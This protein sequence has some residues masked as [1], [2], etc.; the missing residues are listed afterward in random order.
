LRARG[1]SRVR[2]RR[3]HEPPAER[4]RGGRRDDLVDVERYEPFRARHRRRVIGIPVDRRAPRE[5]Q[6][7]AR[8]EVDEQEPGERVTAKL[9][10]DMNIVLPW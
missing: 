7:V 5:L 9:P 2:R 1:D 6:D 4:A 8:L 10:S 3:L